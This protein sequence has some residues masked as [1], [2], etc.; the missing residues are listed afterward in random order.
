MNKSE[1]LALYHLWVAFGLFVPA[2]LL[3]A[4]QMLARSPLSAPLQGHPSTYYASV[5]LHGT[6]MAYVLTTFFAM[7]FGYAVA[8]TSLGRP[9]RGAAAA[10]AGFVI[11][12][13]RHADGGRDDN[14]WQGLGPLHLLSATPSQPV[15]LPRGVSAHRRVDDLGCGDDHQHGRLEA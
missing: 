14:R 10:W 7:G 5:T 11:L 13:H 12:P 2:V 6:V 9:I 1:R 15:V 8:A 3:G 4:W